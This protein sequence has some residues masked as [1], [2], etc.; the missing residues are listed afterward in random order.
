MNSPGDPCL[1]SRPRTST[2][3]PWGTTGG[4]F[5]SFAAVTVSAPSG[6]PSKDLPAFPP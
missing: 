5:P 1:T 6:N 3:F 2:G 4:R